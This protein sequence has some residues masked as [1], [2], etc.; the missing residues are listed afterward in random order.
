[1]KNIL[2]PVSFSDQSK[3]ALVQAYAIAK[4]YDAT[5]SLLHCYPAQ[6]FNRE[7]NFPAKDYDK[8]IRGMLKAFYEECI[9]IHDSNKYRM[10]TYAGSVS[11]ITPEISPDY[12]LIV[13]ARII[14][15]PVSATN[16]ISDKIIYITSKARCPVLITSS[17]RTDFSFQKA[18]NVWHIQRN[19]SERQV[20]ESELRK[21]DIN[22][23]S[24]VTKSFKQKNFVSAFWK[25]IITYSRTHDSNLLRTLSQSFEEE[26]IGLLVLIN[27]QRGMFETFMHE[28]TFQIISQFKVPMLILQ[29]KSAEK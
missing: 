16:T 11:T 22:P 9:G 29:S 24:V 12:D 13:M 18:T 21:I 20:L 17:E 2:I 7:Y 14:K 19:E 23:G 3:I 25:N 10:I 27:R 4:Q 26:Q 1:M 6:E 8:G 28:D 15:G 5:L